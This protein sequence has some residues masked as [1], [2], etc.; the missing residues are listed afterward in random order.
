[1]HQDQRTRVQFQRPLDHLTRVDRDVV[2]RAACL[3]L[4]RDQHVLAV[5]KQHAELLDFAMRHGGVAI[6][7]QRVPRGQNRLSDHP[8]PHHPLR[9][10][11][12]QLEFQ[13]HGRACPLYQCQSRHRG[14][15]HPVEI[16]E[17][18]QQKPRQGFHILTRDG[19]EQHQLQ[20]FVVGHRR[21]A[22]LHE[23]VAQALAMVS[24]IG[25]QASRKG[26]RRSLILVAAGRCER[27]Q[28]F[29]KGLCHVPILPG[30]G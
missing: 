20:K 22:T 26:R 24:D 29:M 23:P 11:L 27:Q 15:D 1:M 3:G 16:P 28:G 8:R 19:A 18:V 10:S 5:Q 9:R 2:N 6:V 4:I 30:H 14:G 21:S 13:D 25:W 7:E 12:D 17:R